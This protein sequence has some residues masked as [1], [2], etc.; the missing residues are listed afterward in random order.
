MQKE[1]VVYV[2]LNTDGIVDEINVVNIFDTSVNSE[3]TDYGSYENVRNMTTTDEI[4][5]SGDT[6]KINSSTGKLYYEGKLD[7]N[8]IP[9]NIQIRYYLNGKE[10][11]A[12]H[13]QGKSGDM[14]I[15]INITKN[16]AYQGEF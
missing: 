16:T 12:S 2:S 10:L 3:I 11:S 8:T 4:N 7:S 15:T 9:W 1:E 13:M 6:I 5:Y 14:K